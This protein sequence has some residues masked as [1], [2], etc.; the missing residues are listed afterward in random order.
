[1]HDHRDAALFI[2]SSKRLNDLSG[3]YR[4]TSI[5]V[6]TVQIRKSLIPRWLFIASYFL[7]FVF[8]LRRNLNVDGGI[9][10]FVSVIVDVVHFCGSTVAS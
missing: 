9:D 2:L 3:F 6:A 5:E 10:Y 4:N 7:G 8:C 1:M